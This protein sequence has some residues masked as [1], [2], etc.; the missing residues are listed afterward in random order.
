MNV[1]LRVLAVLS[2]LVALAGGL[3]GL[4]V[5]FAAGMK[6]VPRLTTEDVLMTLPLPGLALLMV[7][8]I[9]ALAARRQATRQ[10]VAWTLPTLVLVALGLL[11]VFATWGTQPR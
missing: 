9:V 2:W 1:A 4:L 8:G 10:M 6:T 7:G 11:L 3:F 5:C